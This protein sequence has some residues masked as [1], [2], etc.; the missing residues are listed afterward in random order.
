MARRATLLST[1]FPVLTCLLPAGAVPAES[2]SRPPNIIFILADDMGYGDLG[3]YGNKYITTPNLDR[4]A[5]EGMRFTQ[6][7]AGS[8]VCT[9]SRAVLMT[10]LHTGHSYQPG[11]DGKN[12]RKQDTTIAEGH[13]SADYT[14]STICK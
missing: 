2:A 10:G 4:M 9:P 1:F 7:Y 11:N 13:N 14:T 8:T 5:A 12:F 3:C 6:A